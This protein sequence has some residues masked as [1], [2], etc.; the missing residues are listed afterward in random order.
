MF[1]KNVDLSDAIRSEQAKAGLRNDGH[2]DAALM[3]WLAKPV[4]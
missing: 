1:V 2:P 3:E 4:R